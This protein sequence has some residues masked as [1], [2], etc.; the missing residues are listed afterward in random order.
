MNFFCKE[1]KDMRK[2]SSNDETFHL[3][4]MQIRKIIDIIFSRK[5][6]TTDIYVQWGE[7]SISFYLNM[8]TC[9]RVDYQHLEATDCDNKL[10]LPETSLKEQ[11]EH[12]ECSGVNQPSTKE[13]SYEERLEQ[14]D[15]TECSCVNQLLTTNMSY[16][17]RL[18]QVLL[19]NK[20]D[21]LDTIKSIL[22]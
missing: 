8:C 6:P 12:T 20:L 18:Y 1:F 9:F 4:W 2:L 10:L 7:Y 15:H 13:V 22:C 5:T 14:E 21:A 16:E 19:Y 11:E 3:S 17:E